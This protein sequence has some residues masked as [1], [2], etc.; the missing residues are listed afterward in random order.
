M[1]LVSLPP[2]FHAVFAPQFFGS[3]AYYAVLSM[4]ASATIHGAMRADKRFKSA[5]RCGIVDTRGPLALTIPVR[6]PGGRCSWSEV[7]VSDHG[8]WWH[9]HLTALESAYGRTPFFEFYI[10][11]LRPIFTKP[12]DNLTVSELDRQA[13]EIVRKILGFDSFIEWDDKKETEVKDLDFTKFDFNSVKPV[14]YYQVRADRL[15]FF[16]YL[17]I[18]DLIFNV[19]PEAPLI[20]KKMA[21]PLSSQLVCQSIE[22]TRNCSI[23]SSAD[24]R[25]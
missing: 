16:P 19:G 7:K 23:I 5:H 21:E 4:F 18:L 24:M 2:E 8:E 22:S 14:C 6:S 3:T 10:D 25:R 17:S 20:L 15:G 11:R 12:D 1:G 9:K 13:D